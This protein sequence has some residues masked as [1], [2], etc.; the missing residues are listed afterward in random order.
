[1]IGHHRGLIPWRKGLQPERTGMAWQRTCLTCLGV[2]L[3]LVALDKSF[4][5]VT[6]TIV[7]GAFTAASLF[8]LV[9]SQSRYD[10][11][12]RSLTRTGPHR[13]PDGRLPL[14]LAVTACALGLV[15]LSTWVSLR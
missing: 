2:A 12:H 6:L 13:L 1:M 11:V 7:A 14:A 8:L 15:C 9:A 10:D 4:H 3:C 5:H